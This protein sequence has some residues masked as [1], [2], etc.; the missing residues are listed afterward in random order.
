MQ[1]DRNLRQLACRAAAGCDLDLLLYSSNPSGRF[2][3]AAVLLDLAQVIGELLLLA[4]GVVNKPSLLRRHR[5]SWARGCPLFAAQV[6][7]FAGVETAANVFAQ[8]H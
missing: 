3:L 6:I 4:S 7:D 8:C 5:M 2:D 1:K